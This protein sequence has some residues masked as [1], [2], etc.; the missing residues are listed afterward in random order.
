MALLA[1]NCFVAKGQSMFKFESDDAFLVFADKQQAQYV[2]HIMKSYWNAKALHGNVWGDLPTQA[3]YLLLADMEDDGNAGVSSIPH[4]YMVIGISPLNKS[5]FTSPS[6]ERFDFL[7]KHEYTHAVMQDKPNARDEGF[8]RFT[9]GK[10]V[11]NPANP[12]SALW[13]YLAVPRMFCPRWYQEGIACFMETW[14]ND[15]IGRSLSGLDETYFRAN[16][17]EGKE[18]YSVVG[19]ETE[20]STADYR[21][22]GT[23]YLYGT[24]FINYLVLTYGYD[25]LISFYNRTDDSKASFVEQFRRVYGR[26]LRDVWQDWIGF[27]NEFQ[28]EN[29]QRI[30]EYPLTELNKMAPKELGAMSPMIV[31]GERHVAY[32]AVNHNGEFA[33]V[34]RLGLD[35][36]NKQIDDIE[37]LGYIDGVNT[38]MPAY[39][40]YD[41]N[42]QRLIWTDC[43]D[44]YRGLVVYD[45]S[46]G[47]VVGQL[48]LQRV[49]DICYDNSNDCMYGLFT[50]RGIS[51]IVKYDRAFEGK[52][53]LYSFPF[54]VSVSDLDV[55]HDGTKLVVA[56]NEISGTHTLA[57]FSTEDLENSNMKYEVLQQFEDSN[58]SQFRFSYDDSKLVG[59]SYY[60]GVPNIWS[61]DFDSKEMKLL[62]NVQAGLFAPY[63]ASDSLLYAYSYSVEGMTPVTFEYGEVHDA[64]SIEF[65]GQ[66]AYEANPQIAELSSLDTCIRETEFGDIY[67]SIT[68]YNPLKEIKFQGFYPDV[69]AFTD[70]KAWNYMTP[71]LGGHLTFYDPLSR[72]SLDIF[73][74]MSPW[75]NN[76]WK[77]KFHFSANVRYN[78]WSLNG[79]WNN[80][81]F[82]DLFGPSRGSRKGYQI[83]LGY[84]RSYTLHR[85]FLW[86]W[87]ASVSHYGGMDILPLYQDVEV[88]EGV[89]SFQTASLYIGLQKTRSTTGAVEPEQGYQLSA[90][91]YTYFA[92]GKFFPSVNLKGDFGFRLP[93]GTHNTFWLRTA[94]GQSLCSPSSSF[95]NSYFGGFRNNWID[96][97]S[98]NRFQS[99][100]AMPGA[101]INQIRAHN[102]AK[103]TEEITVSPIRLNNFGALQCYP[104]YIQFKFFASELLADYWG[105]MSGSRVGYL[106]AGT[107]MNI[108]I[109]LFAHMS[110]TLSV[111]YARIWGNGLNNGEL[112]VSLKL[113]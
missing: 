46:I 110:T 56:I 68:E 18:L 103:V 37:R 61:Y 111:G 36:G 93:F 60:T 65:L 21:L 13:S 27:E 20:G 112:M 108:P 57:M 100:G 33:Q 39:V 64:N 71:V 81:N 75:S 49:S 87:G 7:F 92:G 11:Q 17:L 67:N 58:L 26:S 50:N 3:P 51:H 2:P 15:G 52:E 102:Y 70:R 29:L 101:R 86:G 40:A 1:A 22:G 32:A 105:S 53:I 16:V 4:N 66:R 99:V 38:N 28:K 109:V 113:L 23:G 5:Y 78:N 96:C 24:R 43:N 35:E 62:S 84:S 89:N 10:I 77:E 95:G 73:A 55:S 48:N 47:K 88:D 45:L 44:S 19:L 79:S 34:V 106:S 14:L 31:D 54:G 72:F 42:G 6:N 90:S 63:M 82:Y 59:F 83:S 74:G 97:G 41:K 80:P 12:L 91:G 69:S 76:E 30:A 85:P 8:R 94:A 25:K 9:H 104:R 98:V 107:Q